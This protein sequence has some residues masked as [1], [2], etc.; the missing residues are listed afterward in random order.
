MARQVA[1]Q[2]VARGLESEERKEHELSQV[3]FKGI[4]LEEKTQRCSLKATKTT[5]I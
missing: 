5:K 2:T 1:Q 3:R 4:I